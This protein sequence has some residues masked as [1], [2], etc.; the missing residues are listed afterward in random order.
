MNP[1]QP[2]EEECIILTVEDQ[3]KLPLVMELLS[4]FDLVRARREKL[5]AP[6]R[7]EPA[8]AQP[9]HPEKAESFFDSFGAW[10]GRTDMDADELRKKSWER[11]LTPH[12]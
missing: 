9:L 7:I 10:A 5:P 6:M 11:D 3:S 2:I 1:V 8:A 4:H 12:E